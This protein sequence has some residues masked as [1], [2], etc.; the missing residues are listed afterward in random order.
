VGITDLL[1]VVLLA[2]AAQNALADDYRSIPD[3][4]LPCP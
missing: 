3:G 1:V 4:L 2:D